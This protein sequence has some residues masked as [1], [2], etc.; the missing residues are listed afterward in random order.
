VN[1]P[2]WLAAA[3]QVPKIPSDWPGWL[4]LIAIGLLLLAALRKWMSS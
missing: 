3:R 1:G 4:V 2:L